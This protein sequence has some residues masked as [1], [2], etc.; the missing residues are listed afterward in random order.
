M[1]LPWWHSKYMYVPYSIPHSI[2]Y[3][4]SYM[5]LFIEPFKF[6]KVVTYPGYYTYL[7]H[8]AKHQ[9]TNTV[10]HLRIDTSEMRT[11]PLIKTL[12][13]VLAT[14]IHTYKSY[15]VLYKTVPRVSVMRFHCIFSPVFTLTLCLLPLLYHS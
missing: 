12:C 11:P 15:R 1:L 5:C 6:A 10:E 2:P 3:S 8:Q 4:T 13:M 14:Y 7:W 9:T